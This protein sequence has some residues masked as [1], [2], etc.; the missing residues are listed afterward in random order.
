[1]IFPMLSLAQMDNVP[2]KLGAYRNAA[3]YNKNKPCIEGIF[4]MEKFK[5][6]KDFEYYYIEKIKLIDTNQ[7]ITLF[8]IN[9]GIWVIIDSND[10]YFNCDR[11]RIGKGFVRA[12]EKGCY[13]Y[14]K[15][16][17]VTNTKLDESEVQ[18]GLVGGVFGGAIGGA[19][20]GAFIQRETKNMIHYIVDLQTGNI[21]DLNKNYI[22]FILKPHA[23]LYDQYMNEPDNESM[24][25]LTKYIKLLNKRMISR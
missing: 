9:Y 23:D 1:M 10:F 13:C 11:I 5:H 17:P 19:V 8:M 6:P 20:A 25:V 21:H 4:D 12:T 24:E 16:K 14:V 3:D 15:G 7:V 22:C 2:H 18:A